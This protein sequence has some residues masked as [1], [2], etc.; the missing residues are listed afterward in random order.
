MDEESRD[1]GDGQTGMLGGA[2]QRHCVPNRR[3]AHVCR[4]HR[5]P[6]KTTADI[7]RRCAWVSG[8]FAGV[9]AA[10]IAL[11]R[12]G[13]DRTGVRS[14]LRLLMD[15]KYS[16]GLFFLAFVESIRLTG[17]FFFLFYI[18]FIVVYG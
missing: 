1:G 3:L 17:V 14:C 13:Q 10:F 5:V 11:G 9:G 15:H 12:A 6:L 16:R 4:R 2:A 8:K 7:R 18:V